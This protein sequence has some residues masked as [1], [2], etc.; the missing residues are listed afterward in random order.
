MSKSDLKPTK[1]TL[2][3]RPHRIHGLRQGN[4]S[5]NSKIKSQPLPNNMNHPEQ[6]PNPT[7]KLPMTYSTSTS[8]S[9]TPNITLYKSPHRSHGPK[10][11]NPCPD[12]KTNSQPSLAETTNSVKY[13]LSL[14]IPPLTPPMVRYDPKPPII[15]LYEIPHG[16]HGTKQGN[17][18]SKFK[19]RSQ[20][21][22]VN[23]PTIKGSH[24]PSP[25]S[26]PQLL[27]HPNPTQPPNITLYERSHRSHGPKQGNP[28][29]NSKTKSHPSLDNMT[30]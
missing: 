17:P 6:Y 19:T 1:T 23:I 29:P 7:T 20:P 21:L 30:H 2:C 26:H 9:E 8:D 28:C 3:E 24:P 15:T 10:Q 25:L 13:C 4:P 11:G 14:P 12:S 22:P 5:P 18:C 27:P 16:S